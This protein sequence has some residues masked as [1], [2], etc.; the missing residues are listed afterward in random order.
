VKTRISGE[1][2]G[3]F[4]DGKSYKD[5]DYHIREI[6]KT[7]TFYRFSVTCENTPENVSVKGNPKKDFRPTV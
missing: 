7:L 2:A 3:T 5:I 4:K 6:Q 1:F